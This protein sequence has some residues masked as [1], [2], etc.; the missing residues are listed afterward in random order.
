M[1]YISIE[2]KEV[3]KYVKKHNLEIRFSGE[4]SFRSDF[5]EILKLYSAVDQLGE[6]R[7]G[8]TDTVDSATP[9]EVFD[10]IV[11]LRQ[12]VSCDIESHFH[13]TGCAIANAY[14]ALQSGATYIDTTLLGIGERNRITSLGGLMACLIVADHEHIVSKSKI[15]KLGY[16]ENLVA[17]A[18]EVEIPFNHYDVSAFADT[19]IKSPNQPSNIE[20]QKKWSRLWPL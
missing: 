4:D 20:S 17:Q 10:K 18:V 19:R 13:N 12:V 5:K 3:I 14:C 15:D 16:I 2:A 11:A 6:N 7:V 1:A 9:M 8:I